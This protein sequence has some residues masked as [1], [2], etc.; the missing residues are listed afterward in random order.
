[1]VRNALYSRAESDLRSLV[2]VPAEALNG[3]DDG[4]IATPATSSQRPTLVAKTAAIDQRRSIPDN[5]ARAAMSR[6]LTTSN[7]PNRI[8]DNANH[9]VKALVPGEQPPRGSE[10]FGVHL[11]LALHEGGTP[12]DA[13]LGAG[14]HRLELDQLSELYGRFTL[15]TLF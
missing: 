2:R 5:G 13:I 4:A 14:I 12:K 3:E 10:Q 1:M 15:S 8:L 9:L 11:E 7:R 6:V